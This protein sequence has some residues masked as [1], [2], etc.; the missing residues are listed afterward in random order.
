MAL[1]AADRITRLEDAVQDANTRCD[2]M[3]EQTINNDG[4]FN[5]YTFQQRKSEQHFLKY[6]RLT[7]LSD[8]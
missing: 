4:G 8:Y 6:L 5:M 7:D 3:R 2:D 1:S